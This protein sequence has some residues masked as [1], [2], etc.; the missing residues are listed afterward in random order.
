[1]FIVHPDH[2]G[3]VKEYVESYKKI[4]ETLG[5]SFDHVE[6]W[7]IRDLAYP[8]QKQF[9]GFYALLRYRSTVGAVEELER[10]MKLSDGVLRYLTVRLEEGAEEAPRPAV[11]EA[12]EKAGTGTEEGSGKTN[13]QL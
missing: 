3:R 13:T 4:V 7:G 12:A 6:E 2:G 11:K 9:K 1:M 5:G 10:T 8:I